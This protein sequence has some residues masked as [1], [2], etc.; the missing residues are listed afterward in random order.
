MKIH[1]EEQGNVDIIHIEGKMTTG[2]GDISLRQSIK[3]L[4]DQDKKQLIIDLSKL[5]YI[6]S[7]GIGEMVSSYTTTKN[8]GATLKLANMSDKVMGIFQMTQ[9]ITVFEVYNSVK[10]A[11]DS[12]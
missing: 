1:V 8:R 12:F 10:E 7:G 11:V 5:K 2:S 9:L 4:L 6:D 3:D